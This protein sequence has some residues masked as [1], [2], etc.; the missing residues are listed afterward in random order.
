MIFD[1]PF[2]TFDDGRAREALQLMRETATDLQVIY[3]TTSDRYDAVADSVVVLEAPTVLDMTAD[4]AGPAAG[5]VT[6]ASDASADT[7]PVAGA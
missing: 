4:E 6:D 1:D 2:L 5:A 3:L 7:E